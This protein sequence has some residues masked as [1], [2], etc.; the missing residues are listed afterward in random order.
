MS[1]DATVVVT[2]DDISATERDALGQLA[3]A[4]LNDLERCWSRFLPTSEISRLNRAEGAPCRTSAETVRLVEAMVQA[5]HATDGSFD[6]TLLG[7]LVG[8]GYSAS[9]GDATLRT[10]LA[11][12]ARPQG[13]PGEILVDPTS[14]TIQLPAGTTLDPGGLGKGL[15]ADIVATELLGAGAAG[16]LVEI[17]GDVRVVGSSPE[18]DAWALAIRPPQGDD[19]RVVDLVDGGVATS[20]SRLRTWSHEGHERHHLI[21][22][23]TLRSSERDAVSCTVIAGS[24]SWAEAFTKVAFAHDLGDAL[25]LLESHSLA[26]SITTA[27]GLHHTTGHWQEFVR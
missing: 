15:A 14:R 6:P 25:A 16:A 11:P 17:G 7:A 9:R 23:L 21:D 12:G 27:G 22:P 4:R 13:R 26:A 19:R 24:A 20:T 2:G 3:I 1:C 8:L 10:S 5:W 18:A